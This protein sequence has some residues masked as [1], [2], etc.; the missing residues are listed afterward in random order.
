M[1]QSESMKP[2]MGKFFENISRKYS[3]GSERRLVSSQASYVGY[4]FLSGGNIP[5]RCS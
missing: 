3:T 1:V 4:S 5:T 2:S